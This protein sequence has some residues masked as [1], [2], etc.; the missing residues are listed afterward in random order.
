[1]RVFQTAWF[2]RF[3][4][5][6]RIRDTLLID[7]VRRAEQGRVDA[8]LGGGVIKQRLARPGHGKSGGYRSVI[9]YRKGDLAFF[10]YG[11]AKS[12]R[13]NIDQEELAGFKKL[14]KAYLAL[15]RTQIQSLIHAE[16]LKEVVDETETDGR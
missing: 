8:D 15:T 3:A 14:A 11:Y 7:A 2:C 4:R 1:M 10:V 16:R 12:A 5:H 6:E 9:L 13:E